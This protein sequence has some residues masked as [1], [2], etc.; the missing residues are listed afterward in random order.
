LLGSFATIVSLSKTPM[1]NPYV[2]IDG[3]GRAQAIQYSD[4]HKLDVLIE[5]PSKVPH[6]PGAHTL[7][8]YWRSLDLLG[9]CMAPRKQ[10]NNV[11]QQERRGPEGAVETPL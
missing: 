1:V 11:A 6:N 2:R 8:P 5:K 9:T 7:H 3:M 10:T 4:L